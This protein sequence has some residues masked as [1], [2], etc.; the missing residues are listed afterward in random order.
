VVVRQFS[1]LSWLIVLSVN[2]NICGKWWK[3]VVQQ[4]IYQWLPPW[5]EDN[6]TNC[7]FAASFLKPRIQWRLQP[8][9]RVFDIVAERLLTCLL[10]KFHFWFKFPVHSL[11]PVNSGTFHWAGLQFIYWAGL[12][13][14][15]AEL[16][17]I[18]FRSVSGEGHFCQKYDPQQTF[19]QQRSSNLTRGS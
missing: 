11:I 8:L 3:A 12:Q 13:F 10:C 16:Q 9:M 6:K 1:P 2:V 4:V 18:Y 14:H 15:W 17:F 19:Y 5:V 7:S